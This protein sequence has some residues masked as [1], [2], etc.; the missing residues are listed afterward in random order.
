MMMI[1]ALNHMIHRVASM[2]SIFSACS[3][4]LFSAYTVGP[5]WY[6]SFHDEDTSIDGVGDEEGDDTS[7][8][9][10]RRP[11]HGRVSDLYTGLLD[12]CLTSSNDAHKERE[13]NAA[14][15]AAVLA[16]RRR[17][18]L[19]GRR[20]LP[21][22][23]KDVAGLVPGA[24]KGRGKGNRFLSDLCDADVLVHVVD[25]TGQADRDGNAVV[26]HD[27]HDHHHVSSSGDRD[28][29]ICSNSIG[30]VSSGSSSD[31]QA[32]DDTAVSTAERGSNPIED[33]EWI[34]EELHRWIYGNIRAKWDSVV[35][36]KNKHHQHNAHRHEQC[37]HRVYQ[38]FTGY[39][40]PKWCLE[41]AAKRAGLA[42]RNADQWS[43]QDLH[44]IVAHFL[45][46]RFPICLALNKIDMLDGRDEMTIIERCREA[47]MARGEIAVPVSSRAECCLLKKMLLAAD[48]TEVMGRDP[49]MMM[50]QQQHQTDATTV[51]EESILLDVMNRFGSTGVLEVSCKY[52]HSMYP[53]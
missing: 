32:H 31:V 4:Q 48:T 52:S 22:C 33:A 30:G 26:H 21:V 9:L 39:Q 29:G 24:Y 18:G 47:A 46:V 14:A 13:S 51:A 10:T 38:L 36:K 20:L 53:Q 23:V 42:L 27:H 41:V 11:L 34:R 49:M 17:T 16:V 5:G 43:D 35:S 1:H 6:A 8:E 44:R 40:G 19:E 7:K 28:R 12:L 2:H 3:A 50:M 37:A 45:C 15:A 25:V